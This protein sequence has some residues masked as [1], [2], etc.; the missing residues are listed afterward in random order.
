M[1]KINIITYPDK[2]FSDVLT[3]VLIHPSTDIKNEVQTILSNSDLAC[4]VYV[5]D[6]N[7]FDPSHVDWLL[8]IFH[9][10]NICILDLDNCSTHIHA[11]SSYLIAKPK[12]FWLTN[13]SDLVYNHI[14]NNRIFDLDFMTQL[15]GYFEKK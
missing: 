10:S 5:Y 13:G 9:Q 2:I 4:N 14:S 3:I 15:G 1:T 6:E 11:L 8:S 12:T 7:K